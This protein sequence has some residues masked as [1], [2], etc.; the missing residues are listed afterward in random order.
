MR[1]PLSRVPTP[2]GPW[3][4]KGW[5]CGLRGACEEEDVVEKMEF[6]R[7]SRDDVVV[8]G[9]VENVSVAAVESVMAESLGMSGRG[10]SRDMDG[11]RR[12][13]LSE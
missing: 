5:W 7:R 6:V 2:P 3:R 13:V 10:R 1:T 9:L 12:G 11:V 4:K 8:V